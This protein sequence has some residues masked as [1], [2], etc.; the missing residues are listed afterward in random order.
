MAHAIHDVMVAVGVLALCALA[1]VNTSYS[2]EQAVPVHAVVEA[3]VAGQD[4]ESAL[5]EILEKK[6][7]GMAVK[8]VSKTEVPE[9]YLVETDTGSPDGIL[10]IH[11][12]G[13]YVLSGGMFDI[14]NG[15]NITQEYVTTRQSRIMSTLNRE[16]L[17][18]LNPSS[19][20]VKEPV[21]IF[22][23]PDC[24]VCRRMH[25][26]VKEL[27]NAGVPVG[28]VLFPLMRPHPDAYRKSVAIWCAADR[29]TALDQVLSGSP[30]ESPAQ[31]CEHPVDANLKL[32]KLLGVNQ[33]PIVFLPNGRRIEGFHKAADILA[34]L[35]LPPV[36]S[37]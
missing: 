23:D 17:L 4:S 1:G 10:Y 3:A 30:I 29:A 7:I 24:P 9:W 36:G 12:S 13:R 31:T 2:A 25:S 14:A 28:V 5:K 27:V 15:R 32:A 35:N 19:A 18:V 22:D 6:F 33:T 8:S 37:K 34:A 20:R 16:Q 11:K 21:L 26:E